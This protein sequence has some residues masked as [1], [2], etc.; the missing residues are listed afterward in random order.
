MSSECGALAA[1]LLI[2]RSDPV[3]ERLLELY[4]ALLPLDKSGDAKA[5]N[6]KKKNHGQRVSVCKYWLVSQLMGDHVS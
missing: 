2:C 6:N 5:K 4:A 3:S 1:L